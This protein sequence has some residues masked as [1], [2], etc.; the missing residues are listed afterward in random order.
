MKRPFM[1][2]IISQ[3]GQGNTARYIHTRRNPNGRCR[4][5]SDRP[6]P[7]L[8]GPLL[9]LSVASP[10]PVARGAGTRLVFSF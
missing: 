8:D 6:R 1:G 7:L 2:T 4:L 10:V 9:C 5:P 3:E